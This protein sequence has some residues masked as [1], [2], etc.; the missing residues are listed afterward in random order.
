MGA[1]IAFLNMNSLD[2]EFG[3]DIANNEMLKE[4]TNG[5]LNL[6][7]S[8]QDISRYQKIIEEGYC[9]D[10]VCNRDNNENE[11]TCCEDCGCKENFSCNYG[12]CVIFNYSQNHSFYL[13]N[14]LNFSVEIPNEWV[15]SKHENGILFKGNENTNAWFNVISINVFP[16]TYNEQTLHDVGF[17]ITNRRETK[18][19][20]FENATLGYLGAEKIISVHPYGDGELKKI[21]IITKKGD[22]FYSLSYTSLSEYF[23]LS[24]N[25]FNHSINT[26][27]FIDGNEL[28]V[29]V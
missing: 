2:N 18:E 11:K 25:E 17:E 12:L 9:G 15:I 14:K 4:H 13:D 16:S 22:Y 7:K 6:S 27:K 28:F 21:N 29:F 24:I 10:S 3:G 19:I 8:K 5:S 20:Y 26:F 1:S 23:N